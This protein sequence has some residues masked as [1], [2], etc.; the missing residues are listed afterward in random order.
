MI[1]TDLDLDDLTIA[2]MTRVTCWKF[3]SGAPAS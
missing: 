2:K 1:D 3:L